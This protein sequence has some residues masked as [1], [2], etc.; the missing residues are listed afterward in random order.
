MW[1]RWKKELSWILILAMILTGTPALAAEDMNE[2]QASETEVFSDT[3]ADVTGTYT[4]WKSAAVLRSGE[5][6][7]VPLTTYNA[8]LTAEQVWFAVSA[9]EGQA[10]RMEITGVTKST[11][12]Y[13]YAGSVLADADPASDNRSASFGTFSSDKT[14]SWTAP[15]AGTYYIMIC[16]NGSNYT[17]SSAAYL[18]YTLVDGDLN[19]S[20]N[21]WQ[22]ATELTR[23]VNTYYN[24]NGS[25]DVD[26][27]K[28]TTTVPGEAIKLVFSNFDYTVDDISMY[29]YAG[30][31]LEAGN[32]RELASKTN[33]HV[34][35]TYSYKV[36]EPG[37][38]YL[39]VV[40]YGSTDFVTKALKLRY[41]IV[42]GDA[43][44]V[45]DSWDMATELPDSYNME[46]TLNG[47]ND[48]DWFYFETETPNELVYL[49]FNGFDTDYSNRI[50]YYVYDAAES[51]YNS[52][53]LATSNIDITHSK[54]LTFVQ[55]GGHYIRVKVNGSTPVENT[56]SLRIE[57]GVTDDGE[58]NETWQQATPLA[59]ATPRS[60]NLPSSTDVDYF[61]F[62]VEEPDQIVELTF[63]IPTGGIASYSLYSGAQLNIA[64]SASAMDSTTIHSGTTTLRHMLQETGTYYIKTTAWT[65]G[66][67]FEEN[68]TI[69]YTL[70]PPDDNENNNTRRNATALNPD[71]A[72][73]YNLPAD[74]DTDWFKL[75]SSSPDQTVQFTFTLPTG[76]A[77]SY[78]LYSESDFINSGDNA[79]FLDSD[80]I[81]SGTTALRHML[82]EAGTYYVKI[83]P[84]TSSTIFDEDATITYTMISPDTNE[85]NNTW[86]T[87]TPLREEV[88]A[89]YTLP[90]DNDVDW[91]SFQSTA[92]HQA[93]ALTFSVPE[94]KRV[95]CYIYSGAKFGEDGDDAGY[96][97]SATIYGGTSTIRHMLN[98]AGTY[99]VK[100]S[101]WSSS[102]IFDEEATV[103]YALVEPDGNERNN[104]WDTAT[105]LAPQTPAS[106]TLSADN[107]H[108][109]FRI[110][111]E[112][113]AGDK[114]TFQ[115]GNL[116]TTGNQ[117]VY[118][119]LYML[120]QGKAEPDYCTYWVANR[121]QAVWSTEYTA[122]KSGTYYLDIYIGNSSWADQ[123]MW[124]KCAVAQDDIP[125]TG[126]SI[127]NGGVTIA[128]G[129]TLQ[130][131]GN[132]S[133]S[134]AT[135][136]AVT[137]ESSNT[138][139]ATIDANG[140]VTA[141]GIGSTTITA[142]TSDG[143]KRASTTITVMAAVPVTGVT[144]TA[145][146]IS[147]NAGT[148]GDPRPLAY[149]STIQMTAKVVPETATNREILWS[150]SDPE[151]LT[152]TSKGLVYA[153]G[154]GTAKVVAASED[155][156]YTAEYW[157]N[158]P[159]E[160]YPV[161]G[162]SLD[163]STATIY[164]GESGLKLT[165]A[166]SPS[167]ATNP[168]VTWES[169]HPEVAAVDQSGQV[170]P[171]SAGYATITVKTAENGFTAEC[172]VSV[173]PVRTRVE[174]ISFT[175]ERVD[176][177]LY[178]S[179]T[180]KPVFDPVDATDQTVTW[181]SS[182]KAVATVSRTGVVT[183]I[184]LGTAT[185]TATSNDD[186][187]KASIE[188]NV[189]LTAGYGDVN[190]DGDVDAADALMVLQASVGL[191]A[192]T[193][194]E[195]GIADVNGD[196][197]VDAADAILILRYD[198][199]LIDVFPVESK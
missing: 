170:T 33:F 198:A 84:W 81:K 173:Q 157:F 128:V 44:E 94:D 122:Q 97:D 45:N 10:I 167:Y 153:V 169:D 96:I 90:A 70:V 184:G 75:V 143:G 3:A 24:L 148:Q 9:E 160:S 46:F 140:L 135:N 39:K 53:Y 107:D 132:V 124:V 189:A 26:W 115:M 102:N 68:A 197:Y 89:S 142:T 12:L 67:V 105:G 110:D 74:N 179:V 55:T 76:G 16:P 138:A 162:V 130:L 171:V 178:A 117:S 145:E 121:N 112:V 91:F 63:N 52:S 113:T 42:P 104:S 79:S 13:I 187:H 152:V 134:N 88:A 126:V 149:E 18:T 30:T 106:F 119:S 125:V 60:F 32:A 43:N 36:N 87:A 141:K 61:A 136:Q 118:I 82:K 123:P 5:T 193:A 116:P 177:G 199:G 29:L 2:A 161:R 56:L 66:T 7:S 127:T 139:A 59:Y 182:N 47:V 154:S 6:A 31:D 114:L 120:E 48:E 185:I 15:E 99:Y 54:A 4:T 49:Y 174:G 159:D 78:A 172:L 92:D 62:T 86:K 190:N 65:S 71:E 14:Y 150:V 156:N 166:V 186:G 111:S 17:A 19:E 168:A 25:N 34:D 163:R 195:K 80:T 23:N 98:E 100:L 181:E 22:T 72:M 64:G 131:Y 69:T 77:I 83:T 188:V 85:R 155:G 147:A 165:A 151:V 38:Y 35:S 57:R 191:R 73:S 183:A 11:V 109:W 103:S 58:P 20:N 129:Q 8:S 108:D 37:D 41:E 137:W 196:G 50:T 176:V 1:K 28:I 93:V 21:T 27:F 192:L 194:N 133:P 175:S 146:G 144:L 51:G 158:V 164:M 180:L 40:P 95:S 101:S